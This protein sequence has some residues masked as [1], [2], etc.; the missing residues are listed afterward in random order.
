MAIETKRPEEATD[1]TL[2]VT[3]MTCASCVRR[4]ERALSKVDGVES[5]SVNLATERAQVRFAT[6]RVPMPILKA[7]VEKAGYG[8]RTDRSTLSVKGLTDAADAARVERA[9]AAPEAVESVSVNLA[10]GNAVVKHVPG[11][12]GSTELRRAFAGVGYELAAQSTEEAALGATYDR[13]AA[14]RARDIRRL[15]DRFVF[16]LA[17][18][19]VLL[20]MMFVRWPFDHELTWLPMLILATPVQFWAGAGFYRPAW[21]AARH[22]TTNMNT[23]VVVG[24]LT[25]YLYS[26]FLTLFPSVAHG[27]GLPREVYFDTSAAIIALILMGRWLEARAKGRTSEAIKRL[28]GLQAKTARVVRDGADVDVPIEQ[29]RPGEKVPVDG[30]IVEGASTVDESMLTGESIPVDKRSG[31]EVIGATLNRTGSFVFRATKVGRDTALAQIIGLVEDAQGSKAPIQRLADLISSYF[32]PAVLVLAAL[33]FTGWYVLGPEPKLTIALSTFIAVLIIACPCAMGLATPTAIMVGTGKG[34][35][36]GVLIRGGE[37]LEQAHRVN[38]IVLDKTGTLT[39]GRPVVRRI[40]ALEGTSED[41]LLRLA[42][43]AEVGSEHPLGEAIVTRAQE[44]GLAVPAAEDFTAIPGQGIEGAVEGHSL[45]LGNASLMAD[46]RIDVSALASSAD[47]LARD[48]QTPMY[49]AIEGR[50][51]GIIAV[52]D[53]LKPESAEAVAQLRVLGLDVWMLTGDTRATA[54]AI[55]RHAGIAPGRVLAEVLPK[56]KAV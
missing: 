43:A 32:V 5:A 8:V 22:G 28:M 26:A 55:A 38:T 1:L 16:S 3:G 42:A 2:P 53:E 54:E 14:E 36:H 9:L 50:A 41:E 49:V 35:E 33:T 39:R 7:A 10:A 27:L 21:A 47:A 12:V 48:G 52:A 4:V 44:L 13:E 40:V 15:R 37:P 56:E 6:G 46:R 31:D 18:T 34:A 19:A 20:G 24:T 11:G 45:L 29:V 51:T 17:V 30:E 25:A 23:L